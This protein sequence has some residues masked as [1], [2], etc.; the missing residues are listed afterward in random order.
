MQDLFPSPCPQA[1]E[2]RREDAGAQG[3]LTPMKTISKSVP[4]SDNC[5]V[6]ILCKTQNCIISAFTKALRF[7]HTFLTS[8][9]EFANYLA[10]VMQRTLAPLRKI[11]SREIEVLSFAHKSSKPQSFIIH[12]RLECGHVK[13]CLSWGIFDLLNAYTDN[14][15][16]RARRHRCQPCASLLAHKKPVQSVGL[17]AKVGVA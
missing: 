4:V 17:I 16:V 8:L 13:T 7:F 9:P 2:K 6:Q 10:E 3:Q 12:D 15:E 1:E 11:V 5:W 14:P